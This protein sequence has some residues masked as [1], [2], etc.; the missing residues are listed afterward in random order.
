[1]TENVMLVPLAI[2]Y[3]SVAVTV[4]TLLILPDVVVT[5]HIYHILYPEDVKWRIFIIPLLRQDEL[6]VLVN[7]GIFW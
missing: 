3:L 6:S 5:L 7:M 2:L 1:M 4:I